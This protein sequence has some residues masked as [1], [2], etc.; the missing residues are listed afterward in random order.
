LKK[1]SFE[2]LK[3]GTDYLEFHLRMYIETYNELN[4]EKELC[5]WNTKHNCYL[6]S[7]LLHARVLIEFFTT[8][9]ESK[10]YPTDLIAEDYIEDWNAKYVKG[11]K[12]NHEFL[13]TCKKKIGGVQFHLTSIHSPLLISQQEWPI[14]EIFKNL[15]PMILEFTNLIPNE[16][17]D[18]DSH[19][20]TK[21]LI[22]NL[23]FLNDEYKENF[24]T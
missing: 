23:I 12:L 11:L 5:G 6:E 21:Q 22:D 24:S 15:Y 4:S 1:P 13:I 14:S 2:E 20:T 10:N 8:P 3:K 18:P 17:V 7:N 16:K 19:I 9:P